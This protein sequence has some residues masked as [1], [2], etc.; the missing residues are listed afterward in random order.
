MPSPKS[1]TAASLVAPAAPDDAVDAIDS[2][3]GQNT[4]GASE[5]DDKEQF[6]PFKPD[7]KKKSW[8]EI[9]MVDEENKPVPGMGYRITLPDNTVQ[10]GTLDGKGFARV[11]GFDPG[12]CKVTFP[13]LDQDAWKP[14]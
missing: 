7:P 10:E 6:Q 11:A 13:D 3:P 14:A 12:S 1:G 5:G 8:I 9:V 4:A 2:T